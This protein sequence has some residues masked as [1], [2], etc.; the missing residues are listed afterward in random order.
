MSSFL[1]PVP[2]ASEQLMFHVRKRPVAQETPSC[3]GWS[4]TKATQKACASS[5]INPH[6]QP[7]EPAHCSPRPRLKLSLIQLGNIPHG[8]WSGPGG[9]RANAFYT[10]T[11]C[12]HLIAASDSNKPKCGLDAIRMD[13]S[14]TR[15][16]DHLRWR[17]AL[18]PFIYPRMEEAACQ[19]HSDMGRDNTNT[20]V[21]SF[22]SVLPLDHEPPMFLLV[23]R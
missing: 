1:N 7:V 8:D 10:L 13:I 15:K 22:A 23:L 19:L 11:S 5:R 4:A 17:D 21:G 12:V 2:D 9:K 18:L 6:A 20:M 3:K 14:Y 16:R